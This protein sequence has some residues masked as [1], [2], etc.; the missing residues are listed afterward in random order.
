MDNL[1]TGVFQESTKSVTGLTTFIYKLD[2]SKTLLLEFKSLMTGF[3]REEAGIVFY[4][5][6]F[7]IGECIEFR[8]TFKGDKFFPHNEALDKAFQ[9]PIITEENLYRS[10]FDQSQDENWLKHLENTKILKGKREGTG[11]L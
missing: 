1:I 2:A 10:L 7:Y 11:K 6:L 4:N 8:K 9:M 5:T 3:Y